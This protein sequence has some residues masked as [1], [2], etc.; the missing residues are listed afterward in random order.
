MKL[1]V[2][3]QFIKRDPADI[4]QLFCNR[5]RIDQAMILFSILILERGCQKGSRKLF[6]FDI[7][8]QFA[9]GACSSRPYHLR[10]QSQQPLGCFL[11][12][13][14][15]IA[16]QLYHHAI[17]ECFRACIFAVDDKSSQRSL[18]KKQIVLIILPEPF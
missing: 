16:L 6:R 10:R 14:N 7:R 3:V 18:H 17:P 4:V 8:F 1:Y 15:L 11:R 2:I 12:K 9:L 13:E 5:N